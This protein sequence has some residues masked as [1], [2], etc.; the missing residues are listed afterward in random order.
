M[1]VT[2]TPTRTARYPSP[3]V[4]GAYPVDPLPLGALLEDFGAAAWSNT[5]P[6]PT[7]SPSPSPNPTPT[8]N[9][10]PTPTPNPDPDPNPRPN[11]RPN[12]TP[13]PSPSPDPNQVLAPTSRA[14]RTIAFA[15]QPPSNALPPAPPYVPRT[16]HPK[17]DAAPSGLT[18]APAAAADDIRGWSAAAV[19][20]AVTPLAATSFGYAV[21]VYESNPSPN[22]NPTPTP[23]PTPDQ[24]LAFLI[25]ASFALLFLDWFYD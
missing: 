10:I 18:T 13:N 20:A 5:D 1:T 9:P 6:T 7:P 3:Q 8:P 12:P 14:Q 4:R 11:P 21:R 2:V 23:T 16:K 19:S 15:A 25:I 24:V 17:R 22:P